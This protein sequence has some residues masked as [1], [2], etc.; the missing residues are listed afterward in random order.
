MLAID[1]KIIMNS[2]TRSMVSIVSIY[3]LGNLSNIFGNVNT[4]DSL[5]SNSI[6]NLTTDSILSIVI[7]N[8]KAIQSIIPIVGCFDSVECC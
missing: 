7:S 2:N 3:R 8:N 4:I 1:N 5:T 6:Y